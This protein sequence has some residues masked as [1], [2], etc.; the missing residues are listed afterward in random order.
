MSRL[1]LGTTLPEPARGKVIDAVAQFNDK[2][3]PDTWRQ[4]RVRRAAWLV[5]AS[6]QYQ[7]VR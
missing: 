6:P 5:L 2:S 3:W 7:I 4:W 1:V